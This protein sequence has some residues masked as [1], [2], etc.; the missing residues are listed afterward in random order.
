ME[1]GQ[2]ENTFTMRIKNHTYHEDKKVEDPH[3]PQVVLDQ[4]HQILKGERETM[5]SSL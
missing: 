4:R 2:K 3:P 5:I 1:N